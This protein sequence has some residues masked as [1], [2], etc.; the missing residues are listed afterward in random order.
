MVQDSKVANP[1]TEPTP[2]SIASDSSGF[3]YLTDDQ[4]KVVKAFEKEL[5]NYV[6][7]FEI[8]PLEITENEAK[9]SKNNLVFSK[10]S[11]QESGSLDLNGEQMI[12]QTDEI[13]K[14]G[15]EQDAIG[16]YL[17]EKTYKKVSGSEFLPLTTLIFGCSE[18]EYEGCEN[19][20]FEGHFLLT[21]SWDS[22]GVKYEKYEY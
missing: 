16:Y 9:K 21:A 17:A 19:C 2:R 10:V 7:A 3:S 20:D 13:L 22:E 14:P 6:N 4:T 5:T 11:Y 18:C 12:Y 15:Y 8:S 1:S